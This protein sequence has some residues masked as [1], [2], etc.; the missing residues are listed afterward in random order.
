[1]SDSCVSTQIH[2]C[3]CGVCRWRRARRW[4]KCCAQSLRP[5]EQCR[6]VRPTPVE[7]SDQMCCVQNSHHAVMS[8]HAVTG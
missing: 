3:T 4:W 5:M 1:M 7:G 8:I 6:W 2:C